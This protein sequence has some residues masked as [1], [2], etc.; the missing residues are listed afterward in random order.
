MNTDQ[1]AIAARR[2]WVL[3]YPSGAPLDM[4]PLE[5]E[6]IPAM[7]EASV[8]R[9]G[10]RPAFES[11]GVRITYDDLD[12][13]SR[14][15]AACLQSSPGLQ[16]GDRI[17]VMMP[18]ILQ[19][20]VAV[21]GILRAGMVVVSVNPLYTA[22][23]LEHQL[24]DSDASAIVIFESAAHTLQGVLARTPVRH[25]IVS[26]LGDMLGLAKGALL[27]F[28]F[29]SVKKMVAPWS[30]AH[31]KRFPQVLAE[32]ARRTFQPVRVHGE[33]L[34]F[35]Q[36]TGG[37][38]GVS[39]GAML[40][41]RHVLANLQQMRTYFG[42]RLREGEE[43][44][45]AP[46]PFYHVL[47]LVLNCMMIV[48]LG[49]VQVLIA[50]P[51]DIPRFIKTLANSRFTFFVGVNT[52]FNALVNDPAFAKVDFSRLRIAGGGGAPVQL[53]V[54]RRWKEVTGQ[55]LSEG[56]GL[57][58]TSGAVSIN[59]PTL[60][61]HSGTTG[62]PVPGTDV[63]IRGDDAT[64][65]AQG[66]AGQVFVRGPQV[67]AGYWRKPEETAKVIGPDGFFA[68]GDIG[69][70]TPEGYLKIV[71]R[72]KDMI[73]VS[74][75]NVYP[76]EL[77]EVAVMHPGVREAAAIGVPDASTGEAVKLF[78]VRRDPA[79]TQEQLIAHCRANLTGYK[80][81]RHV[82]FRD[83]LPKSPIG[84]ILRRELRPEA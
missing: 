21:Y 26:S 14:Q 58:E 48:R 60:D 32:G 47:A 13:L 36:Y 1:P 57:T 17:A 16:R 69:L 44:A 80:V 3:K 19:Y 63:E 4:G 38:T 46:L 68:T 5:F 72:V 6:S 7:L 65:L 40:Q 50:N 61:E 67:M 76:N 81:P 70:I 22:R 28:V 59:P 66:Q 49:G 73:L 43:V 29:R 78:V 30:I 35:L 24:C 12:R 39:K 45:I 23:E 18:N 2:P 51:R 37:T 33:D 11:F 52:L 31:A 79:L 10:G 27:N 34:A 15:F 8:R 71:D 56:Y 41:H 82:E 42:S 54:A 55:V 20:P 53:P 83:V 84:K 77:E 9:F 75:F 74:G 25:V 62:F 64:P